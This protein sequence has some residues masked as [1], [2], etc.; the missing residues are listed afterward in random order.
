MSEHSDSIK[1]EQ[2]K[3]SWLARWT[4]LE[5]I[6]RTLIDKPSSGFE[7]WARTTAG[8]V[9]MLLTMQIITGL[10][11]GFYY[12]PSAEAAH[13]T[14]AYIEKVVPAG[15]WIRALHHYGSMWLTLWLVLHLGQMFWRA[16]Y[17]RRPVGWMASVILLGLI[18]AA[19]ATGYSLP[20]DA[21]AFFGT[22]VTEGI[23]GGLPFIGSTAREWLLGGSEI[24]P[25]TLARFFALHV[26]II[27]AL[28]LIVLALR[29]FVFR[30]RAM[31]SAA[32]ERKL[33]VWMHR[34]VLRN[35]IAAGVVF[36]ALALYAWKYFAPLG[37]SANTAAHDYL[38]RPGAQFLWLFQ[39]LKYL[40]GRIGSVVAVALPG[41]ILFGLAM[42]PFLNP[43]PL[44]K[45]LAQP[46]RTLGII[47]FSFSFLLFAALT[48][49]AYRKDAT[50]PDIRE[51]L[52]KQQAEEMDFRSQPFEPLRSRTS[53]SVAGEPNGTQTSGA[54]PSPSTDASPSPGI[55]T[56]VSS[57]PPE[58]YI[59]S[60][61]SCHGSRGQGGK[62]PKLIGVGS[63][64][65][66]TV[67]DLIKLLNDPA[68]YGLKPTMK[69]F[70]TK[71]A[72]DEKREI[73]EWIA[74][75]K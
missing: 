3:A 47:L 51:Q 11:L 52:R 27:P 5:D 21:R 62:A 50:D 74:G 19:G 34:Q 1:T 41:L 71:L 42:L 36:I 61:S 60:C 67:E 9:V 35:A 13:T 17:R 29:L 8:V 25:I 37:P 45:V 31:V 18:F 44:R 7:A 2:P 56:N 12:V 72:E 6:E 22:R 70:A 46:R 53:E 4:T 38:P 23:A 63:K 16:T 20:W 57:G 49:L 10:L 40:P 48:F 68:A 59:L 15:S 66:R 69:S 54:S 58:S 32:E 24:T 26:M 43:K 75:L 39:M 65:R 33:E 30:E 28:I 64:P 73:A 55:S 14:V